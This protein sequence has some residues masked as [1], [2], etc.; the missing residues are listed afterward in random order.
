MSNPDPSPE[1]RF[2]PG[3]SGNPGGM[4][5]EQ[6]EKRRANRDAAFELEAKM[7]AAL[8]RDMS[9]NEA[10]IL[11]HVRADVLRLIH[12][13]IERVDG[14]PTQPQEITSPD[15]SAGPS[16]IRIVAAAPNKAAE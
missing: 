5:P 13:A 9:E 15:G 6:A 16:V 7:L 8:A 1:N 11:D 12:T 14:K 2:Q 3:R 10:A 4:T